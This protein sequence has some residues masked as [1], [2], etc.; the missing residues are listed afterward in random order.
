MTGPAFSERKY[1][2]I[3]GNASGAVQFRRSI[4][5]AGAAPDV[6][7]KSYIFVMLFVLNALPFLLGSQPTVL[8]SLKDIESIQGD[9]NKQILLLALYTIGLFLLFWRVGLRRALLFGGPLLL[10]TAVCFASGTW[11]AVPGVVFRR[12]IAL[13]GTT[14]LGIYAGARFGLAEMTHIILRVFGLVLLAS[15]IVMILDPSLGLDPAGRMR[16]V[17]ADKN[18]L[19]SLAA[20]SIVFVI[21]AK[22]ERPA[23]H[24]VERIV[25]AVISL[26]CLLLS[27]SAS[28]L[29]SL[30]TAMVV[31]LLA[32]VPSA[33]R[34]TAFGLIAIA[35]VML[36]AGAIALAF[37]HGSPAVLFGRDATL[38]GR[39]VIWSFSWQS[40]LQHPWLGYGY[41]AFWTS[42]SPAA[43]F[44][45]YYNMNVP[46]AH[47]GY[48]QLLVD[49]GPLGLGLFL[50]ALFVFIARGLRLLIQFRQP[51]LVWVAGFT[52]YFLCLNFAESRLWA[53]NDFMT[54][55]FVCMVV[56]V[57]SLSKIHSNSARAGL[58]PEIS[59]SRSPFPAVKPKHEPA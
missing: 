58:A 48:L 37:S 4:I 38:S 57:N 44:W 12:V 25:I 24:S 56:Q 33:P 6:F 47:N 17:F 15:L 2:V 23:G 13:L 41:G 19:G 32:R 26:V 14:T 50:T 54:A 51:Y 46:N 10:L 9:P 52:A 36:T 11:T 40:Y 1:W 34:S 16:G 3:P 22:A 39:T 55:I 30:A 27:R 7:E 31:L 42:S 20:L 43:R 18:A 21:A 29:P 8:N 45:S 53:Q 35:V 5:R 49:V 28:P 59:R